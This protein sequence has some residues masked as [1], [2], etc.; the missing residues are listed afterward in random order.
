MEHKAGRRREGEVTLSHCRQSRKSHVK[1]I[2][3][4]HTPE[5]FN[6][7]ISFFFFVR[8]NLFDFRVGVNEKVND[9]ALERSKKLGR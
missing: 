2:Y 4:S 9:K 5:V 8:F 6:Y 3:H 7:S 1:L